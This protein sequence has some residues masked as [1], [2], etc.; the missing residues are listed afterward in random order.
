MHTRNTL[1]HTRVNTITLYKKTAYN[2]CA[3]G[4][5]QAA[6][7]DRTRARAFPAGHRCPPP[8]GPA[9][10]PP[11]AHWPTPL[12]ARARA[13]L[14]TAADH[15]ATVDVDRPPTRTP[16]KSRSGGGRTLLSGLFPPHPHTP[17]RNPSTGDRPPPLAAC[18]HASNKPKSY[19]TT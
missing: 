15:L 13:G 19:R 7:V 4:I 6:A 11:S 16:V 17:T 5:R 2:P 12:R 3:T 14:P 1:A 18:L 9:N 8:S 10:R